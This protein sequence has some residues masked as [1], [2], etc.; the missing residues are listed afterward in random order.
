MGL[1]VKNAL[2]CDPNSAANGTRKDILI[3]EGFVR[4][5]EDNIPASESASIIRSDNLM[6]SPSWVDVGT[7]LCEPGMEYVESAEELQL[8][9]GRN[10]F[11]HLLCL[12]NTNPPIDNRALAQF[13]HGCNT[14]GQ[15]RLYVFGAASQNIDG[16]DISEYFDLHNIHCKGFSDGLHPIV[17]SGVMLRAM[18]YAKPLQLPIVNHPF[19]VSLTPQGQIDEGALSVLMG[20]PGMPVLAETI[21]LHRDIE[22]L[23]YSKSF[24]HCLNISCSDSVDLISRAK[25]KGLQITSSAPAINLAESSEAVRNFDSHFKLD[26][27]LRSEAHRQALIRAV[28]QGIIDCIT[29]NHRPVVEEQ[30]KLEFS[31]AAFG[32][33]GFS[34][35]LHH[36]NLAFGPKK[37]WDNI[38]TAISIRA[39]EIFKLPG[40]SVAVDQLADFTVFDPGQEWTLRN[41]QIPSNA[42]NSGYI[43]KN[44]TGKVV[45][46]IQAN[47]YIENI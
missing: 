37:S 11:G 27:P 22:L 34:S 43:G 17:E 44:L 8:V 18:E 21:M 15:P 3:Q 46:I 33:L 38:I 25:Q 5:I 42:K 26:P 2:I 7:Q 24:Y 14:P 23:D 1:L 45:G 12:P 6:I 30:K 16:K 36:I 32:A 39:R 28:Q 4:K 31:E 20:M 29:V 47:Q 41:D 19:D 35:F 10:G 13:V 40:S 9:A